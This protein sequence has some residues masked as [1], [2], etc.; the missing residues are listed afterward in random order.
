[1]QILLRD[2][3]PYTTVTLVYKGQRL[4]VSDVLID[5]GSATSV[6]SADVVQAIQI[7]PEPEDMLHT[8]RGVGGLEVVFA[9]RVDGLGVGGHFVPD[10]EIEV[11]GMDYG[12]LL[13]GILGMDF[14]L[15]AGACLDLG[16]QTLEI[17]T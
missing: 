3:L 17:G 13:K 1:M 15:R 6:F 8:I 12:I 5:T 9:R 16:R 4:T 11:G 14:L 7:E 2:N 10:F